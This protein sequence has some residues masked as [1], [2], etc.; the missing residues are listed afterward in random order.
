MQ[1]WQ[2]GAQ[3]SASAWVNGAGKGGWNGS[4]NCFIRTKSLTDPKSWRGWNGKDWSVSFVDP[5]SPNQRFAS[6]TVARKQSGWMCRSAVQR[7]ARLVPAGGSRLHAGAQPRLPE[8]RLEQLLPQVHRG[9]QQGERTIMVGI[10]VT[11]F[12]DP[13]MIV[14]AGIRAAFFQECPAI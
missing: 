3:Q 6:G 11:F 4:G 9:G 13:S 7:R 12:Q 2:F 8:H 10:W 1:T 14:A 5:V